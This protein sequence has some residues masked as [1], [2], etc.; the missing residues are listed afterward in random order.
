MVD[1]W[2]RISPGTEQCFTNNVWRLVNREHAP[3][4]LSIDGNLI[5]VMINGELV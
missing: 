4:M 3:S 1:V 2:T 5:R